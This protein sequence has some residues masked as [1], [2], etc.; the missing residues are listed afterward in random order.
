MGIH[1]KGLWALFQ[2]LKERERE[3]QVLIYDWSIVA[4]C[5]FPSFLWSL[6]LSHIH[7]TQED[8]WTCSSSITMAYKEFLKRWKQNENTRWN[9]CTFV[10]CVCFF[11]HYNCH[12]WG[13]GSQLNLLFKSFNNTF[14]PRKSCTPTISPYFWNK[15]LIK[16]ANFWFFYIE[17]RSQKKAS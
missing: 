5:F 13:I 15:R 9:S 11:P 1:Y 6:F 7:A 17:V 16:R 8:K 3:L 2:H 4:F 12:F 10:L 14:E